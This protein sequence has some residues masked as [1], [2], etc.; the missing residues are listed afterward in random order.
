MLIFFVGRWFV[1]VH[2]VNPEY[3]DP[4]LTSTLM[5]DGAQVTDIAAVGVGF[6][7]QLVLLQQ[8]SK[9]YTKPKGMKHALQLTQSHLT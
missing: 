9:I 4:G 6:E 3:V 7:Q 5:F 8:A 2:V 1:A